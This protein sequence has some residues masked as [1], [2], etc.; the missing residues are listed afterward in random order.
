[1]QLTVEAAPVALDP[2]D[3]PDVRESGL[4]LIVQNLGPG[5]V[6]F[7]YTDDVA[8]ASGIKIATG[9]GYEFPRA[10]ARTVWLVSDGTADVRWEAVD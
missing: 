3:S 5:D 1:M 2:T 4:I 7:G 10:P 8:V 9:G 6:Y